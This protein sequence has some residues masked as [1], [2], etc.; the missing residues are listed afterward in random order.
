VEIQCTD[1]SALLQEHLSPDSAMVRITFVIAGSLPPR[2]GGG[3][4]MWARQTESGRLIQLRQAARMAFGDQA[5]LQGPVSLMLTIVLKVRPFRLRT[6]DLDAFVGGV[7][8][9]LKG[10]TSTTRLAPLWADPTLLDDPRQPIAFVDDA[11]IVRLVAE[12]RAGG[13]LG[14]WYEV[15]IE[16]AEE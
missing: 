1:N 15:I 11:Q 7:F 4:S 13:E 3:S 12:K 9:G 8:D 5:P 2:K 16:S 10:A 6:G 14:P